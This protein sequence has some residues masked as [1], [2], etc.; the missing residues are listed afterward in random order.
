MG[1]Y[2]PLPWSGILQRVL[3]LSIINGHDLRFV[4]HRSE[5]TS[6]SSELCPAFVVVGPAI[7]RTVGV[8]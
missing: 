7:A 2:A 4:R 3:P 1:R 5:F 8:R 6:V